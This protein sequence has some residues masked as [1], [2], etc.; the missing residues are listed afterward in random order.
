MLIYLNHLGLIAKDGIRVSFPK[1]MGCLG[2]NYQCMSENCAS[3]GRGKGE[4]DA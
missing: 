4:M 2:E 1:H 3:L